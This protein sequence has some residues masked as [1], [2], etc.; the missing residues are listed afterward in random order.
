[1]ARTKQRPFAVT[2][3][4]VCTLLAFMPFATVLINMLF[5]GFCSFIYNDGAIY[6]NMMGHPLSYFVWGM[7]I[8]IFT[9]CCLHE[10]DERWRDSEKYNY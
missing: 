1:M 9:I 8:L 10:A 6:D 4:G 5:S 7:F 2:A 3:F